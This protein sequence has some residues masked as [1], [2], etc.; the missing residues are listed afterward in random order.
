MWC[1]CYGYG[2]SPA[3]A[4]TVTLAPFS[5]FSLFSNQYVNFGA[6]NPLVAW[7]NIALDVSLPVPVFVVTLTNAHLVR[8]RETGAHP[9]GA[10][11]IICYG[12]LAGRMVVVAY[13]QR[14]NV[15]HVFSMRKANDREKARYAPYLEITPGAG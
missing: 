9:V 12:L 14:G 11:R 15:R 7:A 10:R 3:E 8:S 1:R 5:P 4:V 2:I 13:C 6:R